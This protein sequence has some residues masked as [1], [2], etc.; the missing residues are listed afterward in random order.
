M[1]ARNVNNECDFLKI[2][3]FA[4]DVQATEQLCNV[5]ILQRW[6][7]VKCNCSAVGCCCCHLHKCHAISSILTYTGFDAN[8][9]ARAHTYTSSYTLTHPVFQCAFITM[10][11]LFQ[12]DSM[13]KKKKRIRFCGREKRKME[14]GITRK[15]SE[16]NEKGKKMKQNKTTPLKSYHVVLIKDA[17]IIRWNMAPSNNEKANEGNEWRK[18]KLF[19]IHT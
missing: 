3:I 4:V 5:H 2:V 1:R 17:N 9:N 8:A 6:C 14:N 18:K 19:P 10:W 16:E 11:W 13:G 12:H 15:W 7:L